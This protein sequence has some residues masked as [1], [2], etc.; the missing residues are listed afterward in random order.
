MLSSDGSSKS[1]VSD[2]IP[3]AFSS[4][5]TVYAVMVFFWLFL[6][7]V[8]F[9]AVLLLGLA[10]LLLLGGGFAD[11]LGSWL[12]EVGASKRTLKISNSIRIT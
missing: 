11:V 1:S 2:V 12:C 7:V 9:L 10:V 8:G 3:F 4:S 6:L 5:L